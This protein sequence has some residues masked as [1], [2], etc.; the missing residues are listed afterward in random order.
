MANRGVVL[1]GTVSWPGFGAQGE[2]YIRFSYANSTENI[3][4]A[5]E[6]IGTLLT[7]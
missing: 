3:R 6:R 7:G 1:R 5:V 4:R 2:G